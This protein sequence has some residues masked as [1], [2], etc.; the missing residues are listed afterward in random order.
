[1]RGVFKVYDAGIELDKLVSVCN[2]FFIKAY[3]Y[4]RALLQIALK[5]CERF[6]VN[7]A[8][9]LLGL[10]QMQGFT[11]SSSAALSLFKNTHLAI[12]GLLE[13]RWFFFFFPPLSYPHI[14][15]FIFRLLALFVVGGCFVYILKLHFGPEECDRTKMPYVDLDRVRV[16]IFFFT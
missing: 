5:S 1:M 10:N 2:T 9:V 7:K 3:M 12:D 15:L 13:K 14:I 16:G 11:W 4:V 6:A 8:I